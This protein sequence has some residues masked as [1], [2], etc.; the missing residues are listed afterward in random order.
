MCCGWQDIPNKEDKNISTEA[1]SRLVPCPFPLSLLSVNARVGSGHPSR[2]LGAG[3]G[4]KH[5]RVYDQ[6]QDLPPPFVPSLLLL[7]VC[8]CVCVCVCYT[9][10]Y[11]WS[12]HTT[13]LDAWAHLYVDF[14]PINTYRTISVSPLPYDFLNN[15]FLSLACFVVRV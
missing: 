6:W 10:T 3:R 4:R 9:Y 2:G 13:G 5:Y 11:C 7:F 1:S 8:V 14:F 12:L 15:T